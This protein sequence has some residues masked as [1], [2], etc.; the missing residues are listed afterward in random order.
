MP[1]EEAIEAEG[2]VVEVLAGSIFR[3]EM[4]NGHLLLAHLSGKMRREF[5]RV[6]SGDKV[7]V[8]MTPFDFSK[9]RIVSRK[10]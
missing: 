8:E 9:G 2:R 7:T 5:V 6:E 1:R 10:Q 4:P 3:V